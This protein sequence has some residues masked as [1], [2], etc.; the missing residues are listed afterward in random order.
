MA[1]W[2]RLWPEAVTWMLLASVTVLPWGD[3]RSCS[4]EGMLFLL[5]S[6][7]SNKT[8][9]ISYIFLLILRNGESPCRHQTLLLGEFLKHTCIFWA[10]SP[11]KTGKLLWRSLK[12][13]IVTVIFRWRGDCTIFYS[14][15]S[16]FLEK[17]RYLVFEPCKTKWGRPRL[18]TM[19]LFPLHWSDLGYLL[20]QTAFRTLILRRAIDCISTSL[21][22]SAL[23]PTC[24]RVESSGQC[25]QRAL[26][27]QQL[28]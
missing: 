1:L 22:S 28:H 10:L 12:H 25:G 16:F 23:W 5:S 27:P 20:P 9:S 15:L 4:W 3:F 6:A 8:H 2:L 21:S 14:L 7:R 19:F 24:R 17:A 13:F 18:S 26:R 11:L